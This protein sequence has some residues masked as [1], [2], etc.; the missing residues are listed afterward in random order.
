MPRRTEVERCKQRLLSGLV[1]ENFEA[2]HGRPR[3]SLRREREAN[4]TRRRRFAATLAL[5]AVAGLAVGALMWP[6]SES[7]AIAGG[8][9]EQRPVVVEL[10]EH[11][12]PAVAPSHRHLASAIGRGLPEEIPLTVRRIAVDAGHGGIDGGTSLSYGLL[13]KDL[14]LDIALRLGASL[15]RAGFEALLTRQD[16]SEVSLRRRAEIA[17]TGRADLFVSIHVNWLPDRTA[18]G[19]E[20]YHLGPTNDPF[21]QR[22][23]AAENRSSDFALA[24][25]RALLEGLYADVRQHESR[26]LAREIQRALATTLRQD[27]PAIVSRGV[28]TAPFAVLIATEMPAVL[29]EV[30]C[31]SNDHEARLLAVPSYRQRIAEALQAGI[32]RYMESIGSPQLDPS[33][34]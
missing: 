3:G 30:A 21:L 18:R 8:G 33:K 29:A 23:A 32:V 4:R 10:E 11:P 28:M 34:G 17:N 2:L 24:D 22:L 16:D 19:I 5:I 13:E 1:E 14:T 6:G 15:R 7:T 20:V 27:N 9:P 25:Y 31:I 26:R 12:D